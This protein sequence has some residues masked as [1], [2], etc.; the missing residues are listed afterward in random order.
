MQQEEIDITLQKAA[1]DYKM[2]A[3]TDAWPFIADALHQKKK[4]RFLWLLF[5]IILMVT[6]SILLNYKSD[7]SKINKSIE[8]ASSEITI[9]KKDI[10][11]NTT[12]IDK[13][14]KIEPTKILKNE[15]NNSEINLNDKIVSPKTNDEQTINE[16]KLI[17]NTKLKTKEQYG[18]K[19]YSSILKPVKIKRQD[20]LEIMEVEQEKTDIATIYN[21]EDENKNVGEND[22]DL[23]K[24]TSI[25]LDNNTISTKEKEFVM[26]TLLNN[27][28]KKIDKNKLAKKWNYYYGF[29]L[30]QLNVHDKNFLLYTNKEESLSSYTLTQNPIILGKAN[31]SNGKSLSTF[32]LAEKKNNKKIQGQFGVHLNFN[33]F[34]SKVYPTTGASIFDASGLLRIDTTATTN[35]FYI[36]KSFNG[37]N[38]IKIKNYNIQLG[39]VAGGK[40]NLIKVNS[41]QKISLQMQLIPILN[42]TQSINWFD[43]SSSRYFTNKKLNANFNVN[44]ST[45]LLW[46]IHNS[47]RN[48]LIGPNFNFNIFKLNKKITNLSNVYTNS[49]GIQLQ[50]R[51]N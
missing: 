26:T 11:F 7:G 32:I 41:S 18:K 16:G 8:T 21:L 25:R 5:P 40:I 13:V 12:T 48:I 38:P 35:S 20:V 27:F 33:H 42:I 28:T 43:K 45:S 36:Y 30:A 6:G 14:I 9:Q 51:L 46:E 10:K 34:T 49:I 23:I 44:Q 1:S 2:N 22:I 50:M 47:K 17:A 4:R 19:N 3:P 24:A 15:K 39:F 37:T 31:Y 29:N